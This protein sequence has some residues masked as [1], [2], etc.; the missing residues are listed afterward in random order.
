MELVTNGSFEGVVSSADWLRSNNMQSDS[1]F[2]TN[3]RTGSG[4]AYLANFDGTSGNNIFGSMFQSLTI[5][6]GAISATITFWTKITTQETNTANDVF[7]AQLLNSTATASLQTLVGLSN[8]NA[9]TTYVQR[10]FTILPSI[11]G[12]LIRVNFSASTNASLPTTFRVDDVSVLAVLPDPP[13][14]PAGLNAIGGSSSVS[15]SWTDS[16]SNET[17]FSIEWKAGATGTYQQIDTVNQNVTSYTDSFGGL[18]PGVIYYYRI[19]AFNAGGFS[20]YSNEATA[21][22]KPTLLTPGVGATNVSVKPQFSWSQV[23]DNHGYRIIVDTNA[24]NLPT[25]GNSA[26]DATAAINDTTLKDVSTYN[27]AGT[28]L[29]ANTTY[30]WEVHALGATQG[31][32]WSTI[33]SFTT[34]PPLPPPPVYFGANFMGVD[35]EQ[36]GFFPPDTMGAA[37]PNQFVELINGRYTVFSKS[38][39]IL[40][41]QA[42][43]SF[44]IN[45]GVSPS[46]FPF[47]PRVLFDKLSGRWFAVSLDNEQSDNS[48]L[49]AVSSTSNP[50]DPWNGFK[51]DTDPGVGQFWADFPMLGVDSDGVYV[52]A[53]MY[54]VGTEAN[55]AK[56]NLLVLPKIS[57]LSAKSGEA[58]GTVIDGVISNSP[59][60]YAD[61][62]VY[63]VPHA[64]PPV[65]VQATP[66]S[67]VFT[68]LGGTVID[69][70]IGAT[71]TVAIAPR[72]VPLSGAHQPDGSTT[73]DYGGSP[74]HASVVFR[75]GSFWGVQSIQGNSGRIAV[76]VV[77]ISESLAVQQEQLIEDPAS[78]FL[79]PSVAV[80]ENGDVA[81]GFTATGPNAGQFPSGFATL[82]TTVGGSTTFA[83]PMVTRAGLANYSIVD[84]LGRN[85][86]G[87]YS[88]VTV[89]PSNSRVFWSIQEFA[90]NSNAWSTQISELSILAISA[91]PATPILAGATDSGASSADGITNFNNSTGK[92]PQFVIGNTIAGALVT[93]YSDKTPIG[94]AVAT[95]TTTNV[96]MNGTDILTDGSHLITASQ[97]ESGRTASNISGALLITVDATPP[98]LASPGDQVFEI[99]DT[100]GTI[101]DFTPATAIDNLTPSPVVV[102]DHAT[103]SLFLP[104]STVVNVTATDMAG[105]ISRT[106]FTV[107]LNDSAF[108]LRGPGAAYSL[109]GAPSAQTFTMRAGSVTFTADAGQS[110]PLLAVNVTGF[111]TTLAMST[112]QHL[113]SLSVIADAAVALTA[114]G[115]IH[116]LTVNT[117]ALSSGAQLDLT[118]NSLI[119]TYTGPTSPEQT[120]QQYVRD[121]LTS[122]NAHG[123]FASQGNDPSFSKSARTL[124]V[125]DNHDAHFSSLGGEALAPDWNQVLVKYTYLGDANADGRVDPTDY[126]IVDG[127]QGKGHNWVTGD[128]N[129]DGKTDPTD[130]AQIDGNQGAGYGVDGSDGGPQLNVV[131]EQKT[132]TRPTATL[133]RRAGGDA[134]PR[135]AATPIAPATVPAALFAGGSTIADWLEELAREVWA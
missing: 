105:N 77:Q 51:I 6:A 42:L 99:E 96:T 32:K 106:S 56:V 44:W 123:L 37:G 120:I 79:F 128:L 116:V 58:I 31:G 28:P 125:F 112:S 39:E 36:S 13:T 71:T 50:L 126:A 100:T 35:Y 54:H 69:P 72:A 61:P 109:A 63:L 114:S 111:G 26:L 65:L 1:R 75:D 45:S 73:L 134:T 89:D 16:S 7:A 88:A 87:D 86:W 104:G 17:G 62:P 124:A 98:A 95:G 97:M 38:G 94:S 3:A 91:Q 113:G 9:S 130:Y 122:H 82:G 10:S 121:A 43:N 18:S 59:N 20:S 55:A 48:F 83:A 102:H 118:D 84:D 24:N 19:R 133:A 76:R 14:V 93:V 129:F 2:P 67:F 33:R 11:F 25:D 108:I 4:F 15:L 53:N 23:S 49:V 119:V 40:Q 47:D 80:G 60:V 131:E 52:S 127:N 85:R 70:K 107:S 103:G 92:E 90:L 30:F 5:P 132:K 34:A 81:L 64:Y 12:Q 8:L 74:L 78:D 68:R 66:N 135:P 57:L 22:I 117:L 101:A 27:W 110:K 21:G 41:D 29:I 115:T 46:G